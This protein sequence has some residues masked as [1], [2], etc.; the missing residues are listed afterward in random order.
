[1]KN[2]PPFQMKSRLIFGISL[3]LLIAGIYFGGIRKST[4]EEGLN[5]SNFKTA[6]LS[7]DAPVSFVSQGN[8]SSPTGA[9]LVATYSQLYGKFQLKVYSNRQFSMPTDQEIEA[10]RV[11]SN[12]LDQLYTQMTREERGKVKRVSFPYAKLE[13]AGKVTYKKF[14]DL[15]QEERESLGC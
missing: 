8:E 13:V 3:V 11:E 15:T 10:L 1:M 4:A 12:A 14:E 9:D 6:A 2:A 5:S 7:E